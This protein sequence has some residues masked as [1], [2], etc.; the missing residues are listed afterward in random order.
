MFRRFLVLGVISVVVLVTGFMLQGCAEDGTEYITVPSPDVTP[1]A[2]PRGVH[3]VTGDRGVTVYWYGSDEPD[4]AGYV[5]YR[6][7]QELENYEEIAEVDSGVNS[8]MDYNVENG[9]TYYYAVSAF[10]LDG[11]ESDLSPE[12]VDDTPRPAGKNIRLGDYFLEPARSGFDFSH[13]ARGALPFGNQGVDIYFGVDPEVR[14][15]YI[16]SDNNTL[17][18]DLGYT[19]SMDEVDVSPE[20]GFTTLFVEAIVGHTYAFFTPDE[21][22]AKIR[23]TDIQIAWGEFVDEETGE[24]YQDITESWLVFDWAYQLQPDNPELA[25][26][27]K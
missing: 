5:V 10:D 23:V 8:Y 25:P 22:Y 3:S 7:F 2:I 16:Y 26:R 27:K 1:P 9:I 15:P 11:N 14:V 20:Q 12:M 4:I 19:A 17:M 6:S 24:I 18:Q 21:R 13:P